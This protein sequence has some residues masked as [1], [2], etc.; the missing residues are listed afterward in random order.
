MMNERAWDAGLEVA[1]LTGAGL[2]LAAGLRAYAAETGS[3]RV[4]R[5]VEN[6]CDKL[7]AGEPL[8][9]ALRSQNSLFPS[10]IRALITAAAETGQ[11]E[12]TL[13]RLLQLR[14]AT[15]A[16]RRTAWAGLVYPLVLVGLSTVVVIFVQSFVGVT[17]AELIEEFDA[18][19]PVFTGFYTTL[20]S[21]GPWPVLLG[22]VLLAGL[23]GLVRLAIGSA[24][25]RWLFDRVPFVGPLW[26][27]ASLAEIARLVGLL[28]ERKVPLDRC[29]ALAAEA[30]DDA[31]LARGCRRLSIEVAAGEAFSV[32]ISRQRRFPATLATLIQWG[33]RH[34][35]LGEALDTAAEIFGG[36]AQGQ[37]SLVR[38]AVPPIVFLFVAIAMAS[39]MTACL[40][41]LM[42]ITTALS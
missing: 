22:L 3:R 33:E 29:L 40:E 28:I 41:P 32:A 18:E 4:R 6:V 9:A 27:Y 1:G 13:S 17:A 2:P 34:A 19:V 26:R 15:Q 37:L 14:T 8:D 24:R 36:R 16:L 23:F 31:D 38:L 21:R 35:A 5:A 25:W 11:L 30:T 7:E 12:D 10:H 39:A 42:R 20:Y